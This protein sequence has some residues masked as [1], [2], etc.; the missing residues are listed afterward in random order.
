M[1]S[2]QKEK[3]KEKRK[4]VKTSMSDYMKQMDYIMAN[5]GGV[6]DTLINMIGYASGV[7]IIADPIKKVIKKKVKKTK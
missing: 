2:K 4:L 7:E 5:S 1:K 3:V 6:A